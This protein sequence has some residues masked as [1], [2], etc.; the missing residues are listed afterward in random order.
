MKSEVVPFSIVGIIILVLVGWHH[1]PPYI[2]LIIGIGSLVIGIAY[3]TYLKKHHP[4]KFKSSG[5]FFLLMVMLAFGFIP[6]DITYIQQAIIENQW[7]Y[8]ICPLG[9]VLFYFAMFLQT[10]KKDFNVSL[11]HLN[12][13]KVPEILAVVSL[14]FIFLGIEK[15]GVSLIDFLA[16]SNSQTQTLALGCVIILIGV[17]LAVLFSNKRRQKQTTMNDKTQGGSHEIQ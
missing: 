15:R 7:I 14:Y 13:E 11:S 3:L 4:E 9:T 6:K 12:L 1:Y 8:L 5:A 17:T 10:L 2:Y 16:S